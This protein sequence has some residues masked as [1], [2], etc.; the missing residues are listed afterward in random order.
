MLSFFKVEEV[1]IV[2]KT[3]LILNGIC[4][5]H[6]LFLLGRLKLVILAVLLDFG[7]VLPVAVKAYVVAGCKGIFAVDFNS[8]VDCCTSA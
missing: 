1:G 2:E 7:S 6:I 4:N 3:L 8:N 5:P